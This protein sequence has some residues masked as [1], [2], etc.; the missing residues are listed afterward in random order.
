MKIYFLALANSSFRSK[1]TKYYEGVVFREKHNFFEMCKIFRFLLVFSFWKSLFQVQHQKLNAN[2]L[3]NR[4][5][6]Q[7]SIGSG[8]SNRVEST[9]YRSIL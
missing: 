3:L 7:N 1:N 4:L 9:M 8:A 2:K 6:T 5:E